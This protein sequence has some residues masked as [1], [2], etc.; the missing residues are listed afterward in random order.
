MIHQS[1]LWAC[2]SVWRSRGQGTM[3]LYVAIKSHSG[4]MITKLPNVLNTQDLRKCIYTKVSLKGICFCIT[5]LHSQVWHYSYLKLWNL[6][7]NKA[8]IYCIIKYIHL[9]NMYFVSNHMSFVKIIEVTLKVAWL[10][11]KQLW[12]FTCFQ[13]MTCTG[14]PKSLKTFEIR[15]SQWNV[16]KVYRKP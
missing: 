14:F 15:H 4:C 16:D 12:L 3:Y 2:I 8:R 9:I 13:F 11:Y 1:S 5:L 10:Y 6:L 7:K